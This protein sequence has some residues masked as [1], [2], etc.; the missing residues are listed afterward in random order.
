M[1]AGGTV[2]IAAITLAALAAMGVGPAGAAPGD[3][4]AAAAAQ[5]GTSR[6][7]LGYRPGTAAAVKAAVAAAGGT[8]VDD[9]DD[10]DTLV[11]DLSAVAARR[12]QARPDVEFVENDP[13]RYMFAP[14]PAAPVRPADAPPAQTT[15]YGITMVQ[16]DQVSD[17]LATDRKLC[18]VDS[19]ID[20]SHE[21]LQGINMDGKNFSGSGDWFTDEAHHGTHVAGTISAVN[22][23][24]GVVGVLPNTKINLYI[25]KVFD[26][27]ASAPSSTIVK[28][29]LACLHA[30]ANVV[31]MSLGGPLPG[32]AE[33][34]AVTRMSQRNMLIIAA[35]GNA[36]DSTISYPAGF[37]EVV[38]VA[39]VD[40]S[41]TFASFSQ[42]NDDVELS[43]PGVGVLSTVPMGTGVDT[44]VTVGGTPYS[45]L[46]TYGPIGTASGPIAD[47]GLG[48]TPVAGSMTG[49]VCLI[50]RGSISFGDKVT[51]CQNSGGIG[52][53]I[54]NNTTGTVNATLGGAPV[55]I[56]SVTV[57]QADGQTMLTQLGQTATLALTP[58]NY[59]IFD[60][61]SMATPHVSGVA[62]L[63]WSYHTECTAD[64]IRSTLDKSAMDLGDP[65]RDVH[66]GFG[67]VQ[68]RA[69]LDRINSMGCGN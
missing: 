18:I 41:K 22:N 24:I 32:R 66:Y 44:A 15:P 14:R 43:G 16:A 51:N 20:R 29:M 26:A 33:Q 12:L 45:A 59:A 40:S 34:R 19:G 13:P 37:A 27:S 36:G 46:P 35:A 28:G 62:A 10:I 48:D 38:S 30:R 52:A 8:L 69:A 5:P 7:M 47:F 6:M 4:L 61:T 25:S 60:G 21:D 65:G 63:V 9:L 56:P 57:T 17:A 49:K 42:F 68:A 2:R 64:Q 53:I 50:S 1:S 39:A 3:R 11:V 54:Y 55:T 23:T 31:S 67:L 58:S